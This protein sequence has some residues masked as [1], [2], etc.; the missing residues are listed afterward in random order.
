M[1]RLS[2]RFQLRVTPSLKRALWRKA[3][4]LRLRPSDVARMALAQAVSDVEE[5]AHRSDQVAIK[6][7]RE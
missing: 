5:E 2:E 6:D 1:E 7:T 4:R 3:A